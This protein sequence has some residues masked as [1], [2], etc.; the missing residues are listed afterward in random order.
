MLP[1][2]QAYE[3]AVRS[4]KEGQLQLAEQLYRQI[5]QMDPRHAGA[6]HFLGL[7]AYQTNDDDKAIAYITEALR[8]NPNLAEAH[9]NLGN[10]M[11]RS[12]KV[13][14]ALE[15]YRQAVRLEPTH[16][17]GHYNLGIAYGELRRLDEAIACN[18]Q[19]IRLRPDY[20]AAHNNLGINFK[21]QGR[22]EEAVACYHR[23]LRLDPSHVQA[24]YNL[25]NALVCLGKR[26]EGVAAYE[27]ALRLK[28][29]LGEAHQNLG[30]TLLLLGNLERGWREY[31]WRLQ[32]KEGAFTPL[33]QPAWD[34][35]SLAGKTILLAAEQGIGD[36]L[37][38]I[39][40]APLIKERGG[41]VLLSCQAKLVRLLQKCPGID[42]LVPHGDPWPI[43]DVHAR[44]L[45]LPLLLGTTSLD[46]IPAKAPYLQPE[47][48]L[49]QHWREVLDSALAA[50]SSPIA[51]LRVGIVWQGN[52]EHRGD[53][54][55]SVPLT[56]F[57]PLAKLDNVSLISL[58]YGAGREQLAQS[59]GLA[60]D[61]GPLSE[62]LTDLAA[63]LSCL[64]LLVSVDTAVVHLAGALGVRVWVPMPFAPDWR[65]L[66]GREDSPWY[67]SV[68]LFRQTRPNQWDEVF[69]RIAGEVKKL[70]SAKR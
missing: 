54:W 37:Q 60:L 46:R 36:T 17:E 11:M 38:F 23:A 22:Y 64:D 68:R 9:N 61:P 30:M 53:R 25:A 35:S 1:I 29:D 44:L 65:W 42:D 59:P 31:E 21:E 39:R 26:E 56:Q 16:A 6:M 43:F 12:G 14:E 48:G 28:P 40:Y 33:P 34:G 66:L 69:E 49:V 45:S 55:R 18:Q 24:I 5:L 4:H 10:V 67:P 58:Q 19:A 8:L 7:I 15:C 2:P 20:A 52:P 13:A 57:A 63:I 41:R 32:C 27:Q 47:T 3:M 51:P 70:G 50:G 62:D